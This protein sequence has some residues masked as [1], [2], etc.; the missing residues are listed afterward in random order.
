MYLRLELKY[1]LPM[2]VM[3]VMLT[4]TPNARL[5]MHCIVGYYFVETEYFCYM[6]VKVDRTVIGENFTH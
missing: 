4:F 2:N 6:K 5:C 1:T 3:I